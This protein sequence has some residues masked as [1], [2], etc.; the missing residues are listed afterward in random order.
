MH[1][2]CNWMLSSPH[3]LL[4]RSHPSSRF[5][6]R[7]GLSDYWHRATEM[8]GRSEWRCPRS[9]IRLGT[10]PALL[11]RPGKESNCNRPVHRERETGAEANPGY[12]IPRGISRFEGRG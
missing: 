5:K 8:S 11:Y 12:E 3:E 1:E 4:R 7:N 2:R 10:Q 9:R 6:L